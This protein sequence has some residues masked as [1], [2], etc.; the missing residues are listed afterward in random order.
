[1]ETYSI[2]SLFPDLDLNLTKSEKRH[3]QP[4]E[5]R[6]MNE[7]MD[8]FM[9]TDFEG[10]EE[11]PKVAPYN[12]DIPEQFVSYP[13]RKSCGRNVGIH[14]Y[15]YDYRFQSV[16]TH[17]QQVVKEL[18]KRKCVVIAPDFSMFVDAPR[19]VNVSNLYCN[20]WTASYWQHEGVPV[21]ASASW[22]SVDS[23]T[24]CYDGLPEDSVIA[25]GHTAVGRSRSEKELYR[26]GVRELIERKHPVKLLVYGSH[27]NFD[28]GVELV[29]IQDFIHGKLRML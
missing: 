5:R 11:L 6:R 21:I 17:P 27:L 24:Y 8:L 2:L 7:N 29:Y 25:I 1:M 9:P 22:A 19:A 28:P 18:K 12:G 16:W 13:E 4:R 14:F 23:F 15:T 26:L 10:A 20:R 3:R